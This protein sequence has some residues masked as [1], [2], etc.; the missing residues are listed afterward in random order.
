MTPPN[1]LLTDDFRGAYPYYERLNL[2]G[3]AVR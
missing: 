2:T 3:T 1:V